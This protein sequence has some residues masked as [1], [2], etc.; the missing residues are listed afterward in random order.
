MRLASGFGEAL[1]QLRIKLD[2]PIYLTSACRSP[3]RKPKARGYPRS[4]RLT[5]NE[6]HAIG[7]ICAIAECSKNKANHLPLIS[8]RT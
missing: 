5:I 1:E 7:A 8:I 3:S 6:H 4:L 2:E